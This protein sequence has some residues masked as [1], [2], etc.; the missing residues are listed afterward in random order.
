MNSFT[1]IKG[2][3][4]RETLA[5]L[6]EW[7]LSADK[8]ANLAAST[9]M[10]LIGRGS[11]KKVA[12]IGRV[13]SRG[14]DLP[15]RDSPL[16]VLARRQCRMELWRPIL[17]WHGAERDALL[18]AFLELWLYDARQAGAS[19]LRAEAVEPFLDQQRAQAG[20][21]LF[22]AGTRRRT[23]GGLLK[24]AA[25]CG[26]IEGHVHK[27]FGPYRPAD[28]VL[29]YVVHARAEKY[30]S[31]ARVVA[32][33]EW[34]RLLMTPAEVEA[35]LFRLHQFGRLD[36]QVA[37]RLVQITLPFRTALEFAERCDLS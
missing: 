23:A 14:W 10:R 15:G 5:I 26:L 27:R 7:D 12:D 28:A 17:L 31:G 6:A 22:A 34:R 4:P 25:D 33:G 2:L 30:V 19:L 20:L 18:R 24:I 9:A 21:P 3:L 36:Y 16:A 13:M 35:E 11:E 29:L 37:G 32:A 8:A 1:A